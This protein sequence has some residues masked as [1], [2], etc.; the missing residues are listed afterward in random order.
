VT[1]AP[2]AALCRIP[3]FVRLRIYPRAVLPPVEPSTD[4]ISWRGRRRER[5]EGPEANNRRVFSSP[6]RREGGAEGTA[7]FWSRLISPCVL[8]G[9]GGGEAGGVA[10]GEGDG[11]GGE[12][13]E[14]REWRRVGGELLKR[15]PSLASSQRVASP[16]LAVAPSPTHAFGGSAF[17][18]SLPL[19]P[20]R[21]PGSWGTGAGAHFPRGPSVFCWRRGLTRMMSM[22]FVSFENRFIL[23]F[24]VLY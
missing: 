2:V 24:I 3:L 1:C 10:G 15:P 9:I 12:V 18:P 20:R 19:P 13:W 11:G 8:C 7:G 22:I 14:R 23:F 21:G 16:R 5:G 4:R 6:P 17:L